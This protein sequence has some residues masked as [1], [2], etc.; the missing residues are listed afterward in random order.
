VTLGFVL[1][2][3]T[4][5]A[6]G[7][8][9]YILPQE[10]TVRL[11][12]SL[13]VFNY[14]SGENVLRFIEDNPN[15]PMR[16][17]STSVD[18]NVL[19]GLLILVTSITTPQFFTKRPLLPRTLTAPM[20]GA[21]GICMILTLSRGAVLGLGVALMFLG[22][23]RYRWLLIALIVTGTIFLVLP[24]TQGY[25]ERFQQG[26][27]GLDLATQMRFGEYRDALNLI[28]R[29]PVFG[30]GFAGVPSID[31]YIGVSSVYLLMA[32]EMGLVGLGMFG[33]ILLVFF[34]SAFRNWSAVTS[35]ERL[36]PIFLGLLAAIV[37]ALVGGVFDHYF[38]NLDFPHS[39]ALFWLCVGLTMAAV[40]LG[41]SEDARR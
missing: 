39:V 41:Q 18:P 26:I 13:R 22:V 5:A 17:T 33:I 15:L 3:F 16:A 12:S 32:E 14:P 11:L 40:R 7:I 36:E 9:L 21:M 8:V 6:I 10:V 29:Y 37:G 1:F 19:G 31:L 25:I 2:G 30:V 35:D 27:M 24:Q 34:W 20:L 28:A 38:F 4:A 23:V